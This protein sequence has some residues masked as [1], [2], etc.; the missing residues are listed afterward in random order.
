[1]TYINYYSA[2]V[3]DKGGMKAGTSGDGVHPNAAGY[4]IMAPLAQ[5]AIDKVLGQM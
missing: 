4:G 3:D 1:V 2:L 5:A